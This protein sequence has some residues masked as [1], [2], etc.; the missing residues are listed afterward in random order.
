[1]SILQR[2]GIHAADGL[3]QLQLSPPVA[4]QDGLPNQVAETIDHR[5][6]TFTAGAIHSLL[7]N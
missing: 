3:D 4:L 1:L 5:M 6:K 7:P 2:C